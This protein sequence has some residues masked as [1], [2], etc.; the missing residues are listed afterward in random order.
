[1]SSVRLPKNRIHHHLHLCA[2]FAPAIDIEKLLFSFQKVF[3]DFRTMISYNNKA[4]CD[5]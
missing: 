1:M 2:A 5:Q 3:L 4:G